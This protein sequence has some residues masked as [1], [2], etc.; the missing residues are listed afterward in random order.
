MGTLMVMGHKSKQWAGA[1]RNPKSISCQP[2][3][4][5]IQIPVSTTPWGFGH[6]TEER[7]YV[8]ACNLHLALPF[9]HSHSLGGHFN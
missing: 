1:A 8:N 2:S 3:T 7:N 9:G 5:F 4:S 6:G